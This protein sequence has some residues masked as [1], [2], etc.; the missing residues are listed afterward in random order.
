MMSLIAARQAVERRS[1]VA[2][3]E[4]DRGLARGVRPARPRSPRCGATRSCPPGA[5]APTCASPRNAAQQGEPEVEVLGAGPLARLPVEQLGSE[6]LERRPMRPCT[7]TRASGSRRRRSRRRGCRP[8]AAA[9]SASL[10]PL[11]GA[12]QVEPPQEV[13]AVE[14]DDD[15]PVGEL[16][17]PAQLDRAV[18][19]DARLVRPAERDAQLG[20]V[21]RA[22]RPAR[23]EARVPA[24][25]RARARAARPPPR[26]ARTASSA[27]PSSTFSCGGVGIAASRSAR[28]ARLPHPIDGLSG[29]TD[30]AQRVADLRRPGR[31][32]SSLPAE[33]LAASPPHP[34]TAR[35][36]PRSGRRPAPCRR[37]P[38][39]SST[40]SSSSP[41][42]SIAFRYARSAVCGAP[43]RRGALGAATQR[44]RSPRC[45]A[46]WRRSRRP[47]H[48]RPG[49]S[50][51]PGPRRRPHPRWRRHGTGNSPRRGGETSARVW[52]AGLVGD[53][54]EQHLG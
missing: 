16:V 13:A 47:R 6:P 33:A 49:G 8:A 26:S 7:P 18:E 35:A 41:A 17:L 4:R 43:D 10:D 38:R 42:R 24:R 15:Q 44:G 32:A 50:A 3:D 20:L 2:G 27:T 34:R 40:R 30:A 52:R 21:G 5:R 23:R 31:A 19:Q 48:D 28:P 45:G 14:L 25:A 1:G 51:R 22:R 39:V 46:G 36:R 37:P 53:G 12:R 29:P 54:P 9:A 11:G